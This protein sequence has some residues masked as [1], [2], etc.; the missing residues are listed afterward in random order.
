MC[1]PGWVDICFVSLSK[2]S[3]TPRPATPT[4]CRE[5]LDKRLQVRWIMKGDQVEI[6]LSAKIREDQYVAFGLS[7]AENR[8]QMVS[9]FGCK[10]L[11][12][13]LLTQRELVRWK[14]VDQSNKVKVSVFASDCRILPCIFDNFQY[15]FEHS[16]QIFEIS[17]FQH[18][19]MKGRLYFYL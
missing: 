19:S 10:C 8:P 17:Y 1:P 5:F 6:T 7:G 14:F 12:L 16:L 2:T 15:K 4:N 13:R 9:A 11:H 3:S 18:F